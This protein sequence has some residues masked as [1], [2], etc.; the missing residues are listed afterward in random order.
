LLEID[1]RVS[2]ID[3]LAPYHGFA[4]VRGCTRVLRG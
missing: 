4:Q 1:L 3:S 2:Y